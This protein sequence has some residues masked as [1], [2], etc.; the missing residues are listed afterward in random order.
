MFIRWNDTLNIYEFDTSAE[1]TG[2]GPWVQ[3]PNI[4]YKDQANTFTGNKQN[5]SNSFP[6]FLFTCEAESAGRKKSRMEGFGDFYISHTSDADDAYVSRF[7]F[8]RSGNLVI[9]GKYYE[10]GRTIP[11]GEWQNYTPVWSVYGG[12]V[13]PSIGNGSIIGSYTVIGK[14]VFWNIKFNSGTT[15]NYGTSYFAF[16][17]PPAPYEITN[18][19]F[20][21]GSAFIFSAGTGTYYQAA[22]TSGPTFLGI[23]NSIALI[24]HSG[25][26]PSATFCH[27]SH[28]FNWVSGDRFW[29][30]G[31]YAIG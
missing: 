19:D 27:I 30:Q 18:H 22:I 13:A 25:A 10:H 26:S 2:A 4:P 31:F 1:Q 3:L 12:G 11:N 17:M 20:S 6:Y 24:A 15:T 28:P 29:A 8:E 23:P 7:K 14:I 21:N 9:P 16:S 5:F